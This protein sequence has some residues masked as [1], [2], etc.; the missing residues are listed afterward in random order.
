MRPTRSEWRKAKGAEAGRLSSG[1]P[2]FA[3]LAALGAFALGGVG[4]GLI[5]LILASALCLLARRREEARDFA[6][7]AP[8]PSPEVAYPATVLFLTDDR[9]QGRDRGMI[10]FFDGW[11]HFE[12]HRTHFSLRTVDLRDA[13]P[14]AGDI[15]IVLK[16]DAQ[17]IIVPFPTRS[18]QRRFYAWY[19][20]SAWTEGEPTLPPLGPCPS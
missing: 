3:A 12:G 14:D 2:W 18:L 13:H 19:R 16:G 7:L 6:A 9:H 4:A 8:I 10:V 1:S 17:S 11:M 20:S 5:T 15:E